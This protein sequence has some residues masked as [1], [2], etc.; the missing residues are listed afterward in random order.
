MHVALVAR[1]F[2]PFIGGGI[3]PI[4]A[5]AARHLDTGAEVTV[6]TSAGHRPE[7]ERLRARQDPRLPPSSVRLVFVEEPDGD[8]WGA[9]YSYM[10]AYGARVDRTLREAFPGGGPDLLE[11]CDYLG[12]GFV[13]T[14][15]RVAHDP[16]LERTRLCVR[17]H[18][19][20]YLCSVLDGHLPDD[21]HTRAIFEAERYVLAHA[22]TVIW[23]G[24]DVL[25]TYERVYGV[26][27]L[28]ASTRLPDAFLDEG[29]VTS[30]DHGP[31]PET[32]ALRLLYLGRLERRKGVQNL[33]RAIT[34]LPEPDVYLTLLGGDTDTAP[35]GGSLRAQ[36]E[37]MAAGDPRIRFVDTVPREEVRNF[38]RDAHVLVIPSLWECWPNTAREALMHNRPVLA[39]P[40]GG[41][42]EMV[43][44]GRSGWLTD[45]RSATA[46]CDAIEKLAARPAEVRDMIESGSPRA[47]FEE[48]ADPRALVEGYQ[49]LASRGP[50]RP[51]ATREDPLVSIVI[52]YH[53][54]ESY[55]RETV[56]SAAA[57]THAAIEIVIVN[58]GSLHSED[59]VVYELAEEFGAR[60]VTQVNSGLGAARNFGISQSR[61]RYV[62]PLDAD[63]TIHPTFVARC[64]HAL[65]RDP[66]LAYVTT[67]VE[68]MDP[69]G[70][71]VSDV[72]GG[73][74][75]FGNWTDLIERNNVGG[76][77]SAVLRRRLFELGFA[78][79]TDLT[80]YEDWL[81]YLQLHRAGRYGAVI[82]ERL[83]RY[84]LRDA[85]MTR[86]LGAPSLGRHYAELRAHQREEEIA[87]TATAVE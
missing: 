60:I 82:P 53:R 56:A 40:V 2:Y 42:C 22:D 52:P 46:I 36:L 77:C 73:Y 48:L 71:A 63:D 24:G 50:A 5:A 54:L 66:S 55:V 49:A 8:D 39:T 37:L 35:L 18:T 41:L 68:Y 20:A 19:T 3:A 13:T 84:R 34:G 62:L 10:H 47:V 23:P 81:L 85:S 75:P 6:V 59:A 43:K 25:A 51:R 67:W 58:D 14:Q 64:V 31:P 11:F 33:V 27:G 38:I 44:P 17:L 29:L 83:I 15:A 61:G 4:V 26:E 16:W 76:T 74:V 86:T 87:W 9:F 78:Y 79:S 7:Y 65:E 28:A 57:Q 32:G 1:E 72:D 21:F 45:D 70:R 30:A 69:E 12:E 80:S